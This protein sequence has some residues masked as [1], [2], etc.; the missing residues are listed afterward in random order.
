[1][2]VGHAAMASL[3]LMRIFQ[4]EKAV[5]SRDANENLERQAD[6]PRKFPPIN[7]KL[8]RG[9]EPGRVLALN[10]RGGK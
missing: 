6:N 1:M 3:I 4:V 7:K 2:A 10:R 9:L 5:Y 8:L